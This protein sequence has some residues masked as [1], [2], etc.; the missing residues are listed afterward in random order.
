MPLP[1][2][3][4][5]K[6][7]AITT[8]GAQWF[9]SCNNTVP[10]PFNFFTKQEARTLGRIYNQIIPEDDLPGAVE[11]GALD[12]I[13]LLLTK[14]QSHLQEA[15]RN[16]LESVENSCTKMH[17]QKLSEINSDQQIAF[18]Q[19][20]EKNEL[21]ETLWNGMSANFFQLVRKH[22]IEGYFSHPR[23]GGNKNLAGYRLLKYNYVEV[24]PEYRFTDINF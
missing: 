1:R 16:G 15:Y 14:K 20:M 8:I 13:D 3:K 6:N 4:F 2:R 22:T 7:I 23:H 12:Y 9:F 19:L 10:S 24:D 5:I 17:G 21:D 11:A 18:L